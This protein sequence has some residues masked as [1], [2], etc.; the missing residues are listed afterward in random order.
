LTAEDWL[1]AFNSHPKIGESKAA[2]SV[3]ALAQT[4]S[5]QEQAAVDLSGQGVNQELTRLN[6]AY[7]AKFGYIFIVCASGRSSD[8]I[9]RVL[10]NR[11]TN[12]ASR[13]ILIAASE[14]EKITKL[15]LQKLLD[16][17]SS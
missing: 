1:E 9:L 14:Q 16:Q 15:R 3:S 7:E 12:D 6:S 17:N 2:Q 4:W 13:E 11:L 8:E 10:H 5:A